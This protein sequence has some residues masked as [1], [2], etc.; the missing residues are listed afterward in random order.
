MTW[1]VSCTRRW[2]HYELD[3]VASALNN[4]P[5]KTL[6]W[7]TPAEAMTEQILSLQQASVATTG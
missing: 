1:P 7:K 2:N 6:G 3:A 5:R 4:R